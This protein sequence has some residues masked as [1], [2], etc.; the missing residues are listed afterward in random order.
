M[1]LAVLPDDGSLPRLP[2]SIAGCQALEQLLAA[3]GLDN[4]ADNQRQLLQAVKAGWNALTEGT[5]S[6]EA[7]I[8]LVE[9]WDHGQQ[10]TLIIGTLQPLQVDLEARRIPH[11]QNRII[12][13]NY[14]L[15]PEDLVNY[16]AQDALRAARNQHTH[17]RKSSTQRYTVVFGFPVTGYS[18]CGSS[19]DLGMALLALCDLEKHLNLRQQQAC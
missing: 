2:P 11:G 10:E 13:D 9:Q 4:L 19:F 17:L 3:P 5:S 15:G 7:W 18:Y 6:T 8:P 16:H 1:A 12:F 14:P